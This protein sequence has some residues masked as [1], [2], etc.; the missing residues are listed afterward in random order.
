MSQDD[1]QEE[2]NHM[3]KKCL[4]DS[5]VQVFEAAIVV[6]H[7]LYFKKGDQFEKYKIFLQFLHSKVNRILESLDQFNHL[8]V[9]AIC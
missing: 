5:S 3:I 9:P 8:C 4:N 2:I 7:Q 6:G 1:Y